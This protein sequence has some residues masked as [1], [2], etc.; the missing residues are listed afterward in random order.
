[1]NQGDIESEW[2]IVLGPGGV[3]A[4]KYVEQKF[5]GKLGKM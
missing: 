5:L 1:L 4:Q 2:I 3:K